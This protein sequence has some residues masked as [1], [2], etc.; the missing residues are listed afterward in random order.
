MEQYFWIDGRRNDELGVTLQSPIEFSN[1]VPCV[2]SQHIPGKNGDLHYWDGSYENITGTAKCFVLG[3]NPENAI[4]NINSLFLASPGY[5]R[6]EVSSEPG[7]FRLARIRKGPETNIRCNV[8]APFSI[9]F[10]CM[11]QRWD[12]NGESVHTAHGSN[13]R[14]LDMTIINPYQFEAKPLIRLSGFEDGIVAFPLSITISDKD[15]TKAS[16]LD[17]LEF[18]GYI[19][20]D[21]ENQNVYSGETNMNNLVEAGLF[22]VLFPGENKITLA[23]RSE[24]NMSGVTMEVTPRWWTL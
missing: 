20:I 2:V 14:F 10:D 21:S 18:S 7:F 9:E 8:L 1:P 19:D 23:A 5:H 3:N 11:P 12:V 4:M 15:F 22:P 13:N 6:L 17:I 16:V 24:S